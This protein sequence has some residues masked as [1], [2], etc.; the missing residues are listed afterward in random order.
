MN[1]IAHN[2]DY[3]CDICNVIRFF[4]GWHFLELA[5]LPI[6]L[7]YSVINLAIN[8]ICTMSAGKVFQNRAA[9]RTASAV[10]LRPQDV[11][12]NRRPR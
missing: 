4:L 12:P 6:G 1:A 2:A 9:P 11:P 3:A 10:R 8:C 7:A 5:L